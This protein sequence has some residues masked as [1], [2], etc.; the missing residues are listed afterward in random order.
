MHVVTHTADG[1]YLVAVV[2][3]D[4]HHVLIQPVPPAFI[5]QREP[6]LNGEYRVDMNL[7]VCVWHCLVFWRIPMG[8]RWLI[9]LL[10]YRA[11]HPYGMLLPER[12]GSISNR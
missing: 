7:C 1:K 6:V 11:L 3:N 2:L 8:C 9:V 4:R 12:K 10:F 5:Y